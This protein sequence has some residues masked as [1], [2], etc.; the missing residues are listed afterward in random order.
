MSVSV[1][2]TKRERRRKLSS[3]DVVTMTRW[4]INYREP[5]TG[6]RRQLFFE[7]ARDAQLKRNEIITEF[8]T[9]TYSPGRNAITVAEAMKRWLTNRTGEIKG[10]SLEGYEHYAAYITGPLLIGTQS[11][12]RKFTRTG[13]RPRETRLV[14]LLG[15]I[16]LQ[17]L[18][19]S[20]IRAWH[21]TVSAEVSLYAANRAKQYLAAAMSLAAEDMNIRPPAMPTKLGRGKPKAKK[22]I[23]TPDQVAT[24]LQAALENGERGIYVAFPFLAGTRPSEQLGLL[25]EDI[26]FEANVIRIQRMQE[27]D[28]KLCDITKTAAGTREIPLCALLR[29]MLLEWRVACPRVDGKL[30]R[31]FPGPGQQQPWPYRGS[32]EAGPSSTTISAIGSGCLL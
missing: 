31:V 12:R 5:K 4:V 28:G 8:G 19:T 18:S 6:K 14:P 32:A 9:G 1:N 10:G 26:D 11:E 2:I 7:R 27:R 13:Q 17:D 29:S 20:E 25:W 3:G 24:L 23:L 21:R 30:H 15:A 16:K 22:L